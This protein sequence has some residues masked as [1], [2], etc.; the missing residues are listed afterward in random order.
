MYAGIETLKE[1]AG[2]EY[3][4]ISE[5]RL[6]GALAN[7]IRRSNAKRIGLLPDIST[8]KIRFVGN[9]A[10]AGARMALASRSCRIHAEEISRAS[11][12]VELAGR[13]DFQMRFSEA[14]LFPA[15]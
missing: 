2:I 5:V 1:E 3:E 12:Y 6:A 9:A 11:T 7:F 14:M 15:R 13:T 4:A 10:L 8:E